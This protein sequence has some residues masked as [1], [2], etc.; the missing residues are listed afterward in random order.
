MRTGIR[1]NGRSSERRRPL[2]RR[3]ILLTALVVGLALASCSDG[4]STAGGTGGF[5]TPA[6]GTVSCPGNNYGRGILRT[7]T[8]PHVDTVN[9]LRYHFRRWIMDGVLPPDSR[10]PTLRGAKGERNL[11]EPT[12]EAMGFPTIPVAAVGAGWR[13]TVP[14][15][16]FINPVLDYD[17]G[18]RRSSR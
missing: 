14:E 18:P 12:Q 8:M 5:N 15:A 4:G 10:Y 9:A 6:P 16:G 11:V 2:R 7:N 17:W 13:T 3:L 1:R